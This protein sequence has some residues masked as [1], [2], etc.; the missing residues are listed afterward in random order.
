MKITDFSD[1]N[2]EGDEVTFDINAD[3][4][5]NVNAKD[6]ATSREQAMQI[7]PSSGLADEEID[8]M[9]KDAE[10]H[11]SDDAKRKD[12]V[13]ASNLADSAVYSGEKFIQENGENIS[14][15]QKSSIQ[16]EIDN[17]KSALSGPPEALQLAVDRLDRREPGVP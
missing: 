5:L 15:D 14:D 12:S 16:A 13:E 10:K 11:A 2:N 9:I 17:V 7:L 8:E 3:G 1:G 6:K 4:I